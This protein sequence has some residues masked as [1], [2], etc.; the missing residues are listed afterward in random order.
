MIKEENMT[1]GEVYLLIGMILM[2]VGGGCITLSNYLVMSIF[3]LG[4]L[5]ML[6][7]AHRCGRE[8]E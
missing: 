3:I 8:M 7:A 2:F 5:L 6:L 1:R 4:I